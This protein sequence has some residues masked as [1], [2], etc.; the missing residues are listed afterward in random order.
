MVETWVSCLVI[1]RPMTGE[2]LPG[3]GGGQGL[4]PHEL[5]GEESQGE[6]QESP[7]CLHFDSVGLTAGVRPCVL[8]EAG[9]EA[10]LGSLSLPCVEDQAIAVSSVP[11]ETP[12]D[13]IRNGSHSAYPTLVHPCTQPSAAGTGSC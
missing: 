9:L 1:P 2:Q 4:V 8:S 7:V 6:A 12:G 10:A 13:S 5:W 11:L 3:V